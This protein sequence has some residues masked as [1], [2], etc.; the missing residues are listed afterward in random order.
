MHGRMI[1]FST[2]QEN[3]RSGRAR[4]T[5]CASEVD[6]RTRTRF[7]FRPRQAKSLEIE[8][9]I[10][11][12]FAFFAIRDS[13]AT[14]VGAH[15]CACCSAVRG[16]PSRTRTARA[17]RHEDLAALGS[18][19]TFGRNHRPPVPYRRVVAARAATRGAPHG[20]SAGVLGRVES[21]SEPSPAC[22][23]KIASV[24]ADR[25]SDLCC[26]ADTRRALSGRTRA[27]T[28]WRRRATTASTFT[29]KGSAIDRRAR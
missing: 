2:R 23:S 7:A 20:R 22:A 8:R 27:R 6:G 3:D 14:R 15:V 28:S 17:H 12:A 25:S 16:L 18:R 29:P 19:S 11:F 1:E 5:S 9:A 4:V 24:V 26:R 13:R 21:A 10:V